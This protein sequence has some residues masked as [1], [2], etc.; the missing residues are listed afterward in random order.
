MMPTHVT[1]G[2]FSDDHAMQ[3]LAVEPLGTTDRY[4]A[5]VYRV[6]ERHTPP[7]SRVLLVDLVDS[8]SAG[9]ELVRA[10]KT[11]SPLRSRLL[12][13]NRRL[14]L[15]SALDPY[16]YATAL[17][18]IATNVAANPSQLL[19]ETF[20]IVNGA[21]VADIG[22]DTVALSLSRA[23]LTAADGSILWQTIGHP[24]TENIPQALD[25]EK[26]EWKPQEPNGT[27][28]QLCRGL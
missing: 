21:L 10:G 17:T 13:A 27:L 24:S 20:P 4:C 7:T 3:L 15:V 22:P 8:R 18:I 1:L 23:T 12:V 19:S 5:L 6:V 28:M 26:L 25:V 9:V 11:E 16:L 14:H 2:Q